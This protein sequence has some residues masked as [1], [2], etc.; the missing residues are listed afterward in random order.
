MK[1][2]L[3]V[4]FVLLF[5]FATF[6]EVSY[7]EFKKLI[8]IFH[9]EYDQE[10]SLQNAN[11]KV[12]NTSPGM[13]PDMW[14]KMPTVR[15]SYSSITEGNIKTH[16]LFLFGGYAKIE[17]MTIEG[18]ANTLCHEL[19]HG[20][21]GAPYKDSTG[22]YVVSTEGQA[23]YY[24]TSICLRRILKHIP[25]KKAPTVVDGFVDGKCRRHF[26][27]EDDLKTCYRSFETLENER[28]FFRIEVNGK[29]TFYDRPDLSVVSRVNTKADFYPDSQCR[30]D[31]MVNGV[32][33]IERPRCWFKAK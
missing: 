31:T 10:L 22:S 11:F 25:P 6:A 27:N 24:A 8:E 23:D 29:E 33:R 17:G 19:G 18:L 32:L 2:Y 3:L 1:K 14:W 12:N 28:T 15:A 7:P 30:L 20:I 13:D 21:G 26:K 4:T 16:L 9:K 5:S